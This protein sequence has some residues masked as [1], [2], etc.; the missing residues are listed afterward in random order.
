M[1]AEIFP[2]VRVY[3]QAADI[4][5]QVLNFGLSAPV[6]VQISGQ[7]LDENY[8]AGLRL[9]DAMRRIPGLI[10]VRIAQ[11]LDYP[12]LRVNVDRA[13]ALE[14]GVDQ[15]SVAADLLTSLSTNA[16]LAP[17]Y[18]LDPRNGVNYSVLEQVPQH[19]VDSV[20]ALCS[21]PLMPA[22]PARLDGAPQLLSNVA[23]VSEGVEPAIVNHYDVQRV[24]DVDAGVEGRDLGG[25][26]AAVQDAIGHLGQLPPGMRIK[27]RGQ[28]QAMNESFASL[29][30]GIVLAIVLVYLLMVANFQ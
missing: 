14:L 5:S 29:E 17:N 26:T 2:G 6:D 24:I 15:R 10:D 28:S 27:I 25:A 30:L 12:T 11:M 7:K 9:R 19:M 4:V 21:T 16:I 13:K 23:T 1:V 18:W 22:N 8:A 3:F 20:Q